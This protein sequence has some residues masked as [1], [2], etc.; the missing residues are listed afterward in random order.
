M[1]GSPSS[2]ASGPPRPRGSAM[3]FTALLYGASTLLVL[4]SCWLFLSNLDQLFPGNLKAS[5]ALDAWRDAPQTVAESLMNNSSFMTLRRFEPL[6]QYFP[7][8]Q[9]WT[10]SFFIR[11]LGRTTAQVKAAMM[12]PTSR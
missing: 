7:N 2:L 12:K 8:N 5:P 3:L 6:R 11:S 4:G 10:P 9:L 1:S